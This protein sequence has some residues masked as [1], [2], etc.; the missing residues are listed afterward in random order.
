MLTNEMIAEQVLA[1]MTGCQH[2]GGNHRGHYWGA[3]ACTDCTGDAYQLYKRLRKAQLAEMPRCEVPGCRARGTL[4]VARLT[5]M[6]GRHFHKAESEMARQSG[7]MFFGAVY[8]SKS[9]LI[10]MATA[11]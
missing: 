8:P 10:E 1:V 9:A 5:L 11:C 6:C 7:G 3:T 4:T 2:E